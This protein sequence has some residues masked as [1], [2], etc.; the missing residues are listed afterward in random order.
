MLHL[1]DGL[2]VKGGSARPLEREHAAA[3]RSW[4]RSADRPE[5]AGRVRCG[6][7]RAVFDKGLGGVGGR[8]DGSRDGGCGGR[9]GG[10]RH[11]IRF[12]SL[13]V[14]LGGLWR[15]DRLVAVESDAMGLVIG[16]LANT[17]TKQELLGLATI[18]QHRELHVTL[19]AA[20]DIE[21]FLVCGNWRVVYRSNDV[22][23]FEAARRVREAAW[24]D[25][26]DAGVGD[27]AGK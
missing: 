20:D 4:R 27:I 11:T 6:G 25:R 24:F 9:R 26:L 8:R 5:G 19:R 15:R 3:V 21:G 16:R 1:H 23:R 18:P 14:E 17:L 7:D 2:S 10:D 12:R 22:H 13:S